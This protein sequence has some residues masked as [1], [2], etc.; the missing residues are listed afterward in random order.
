MLLSSYLVCFNLVVLKSVSWFWGPDVYLWRDYSRQ[1]R[2]LKTG[3]KL[4]CALV[5]FK[6][7]DEVIDMSIS[8]TFLDGFGTLQWTFIIHNNTASAASPPSP[9]GHTADAWDWG[10]VDEDSISSPAAWRLLFAQPFADRYN[11]FCSWSRLAKSYVVSQ[12]NQSAHAQ[13]LFSDGCS[14]FS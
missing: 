4:F 3:P 2:L 11:S 7:A 14:V 12:Q 10:Q 1:H 8:Y 9:P 13:Q 5:P 6:D